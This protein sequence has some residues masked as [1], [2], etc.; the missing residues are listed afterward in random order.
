M[1]NKIQEKKLEDIS[2]RAKHVLNDDQFEIKGVTL[3]NKDICTIQFVET[4]M[5]AESENKG[6]PQCLEQ[7]LY[8]KERFGISDAAYHELSMP[9]NFHDHGN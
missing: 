2:N 8:T 5:A 1:F 7:V 3:R 9:H 4:S 6:D